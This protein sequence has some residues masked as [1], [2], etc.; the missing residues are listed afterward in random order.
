VP[1]KLANA[2]KHRLSNL[3]VMII[4]P[5]SLPRLLISRASI[6]CAV[7]WFSDAGP[8]C[9]WRPAKY[10]QVK[11]KGLRVGSAIDTREALRLQKR[12]MISSMKDMSRF[13]V[14]M[15]ARLRGG[16]GGDRERE[17]WNQRSEEASPLAYVRVS[18]SVPASPPVRLSRERQRFVLC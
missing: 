16:G 10:Q 4:C 7:R 11:T 9:D 3:K 18:E 17:L 12:S 13:K 5:A 15:C 6:F 8:A 14:P 1:A 2:I